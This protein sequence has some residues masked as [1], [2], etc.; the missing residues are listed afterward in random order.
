MFKS[1]KMM[2]LFFRIYSVS[3]WPDILEK[4]GKE[5]FI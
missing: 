4:K 5:S 1:R 2:A 3:T